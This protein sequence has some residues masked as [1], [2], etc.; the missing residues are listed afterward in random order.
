[1]KIDNIIGIRNLL[2]GRLDEK[3][4]MQD[5]YAVRNFFKETED[6]YNFFVEEYNK[7][8][9]EGLIEEDKIKRIEEIISIERDKELTKLPMS[10]FGEISPR[11]VNLI[12]DIIK[13]P[14]N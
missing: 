13:E 12:I 3:M 2:S 10:V 6:D 8:L 11:E 1:M 14:S 5:A 4:S 9:A 7:V